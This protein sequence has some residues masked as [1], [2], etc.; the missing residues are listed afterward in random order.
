[1]SAGGGGGGGGLNTFFWGPKL[2]EASG[3]QGGFFGDFYFRKI[4][5]QMQACLLAQRCHDGRSHALLE[6]V[7][8]AAIA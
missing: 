2:L 7:G 3:S 8:L 5:E 6:Y 1:M 4:L